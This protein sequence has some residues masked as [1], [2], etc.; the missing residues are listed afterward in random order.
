M[1]VALSLFGCG[2]NSHPNNGV[3]YYCTIP[4]PAGSV[5]EKAGGFVA[6]TD[7]KGNSNWCRDVSGPSSQT[8]CSNACTD[9][10]P[11]F[12]N[13]D[14][15]SKV[16]AIEAGL[17]TLLNLW[18]SDL[19]ATNN[20]CSKGTII[21]PPMYDCVQRLPD[22]TCLKWDNRYTC[23]YTNASNAC[24]SS[25][26]VTKPALGVASAGF[27]N[28]VAA[29]RDEVSVKVQSEQDPSK[30]GEMRAKPG[31]RDLSFNLD[32]PTMHITSLTMPFESFSFDNKW[33]TQGSAM[34]VGSDVTATQTSPFSYSIPQGKASFSLTA[35]D[36]G[37]AAYTL[38]A[39]NSSAITISID[40][41]LGPQI[42]GTLNGAIDGHPV[43]AEIDGAQ[44]WINR[45]PVAI[46]KVTNVTFNSSTFPGAH[47]VTQSCLT[48]NGPKTWTWHGVPGAKV[49]V[50][51]DASPSYN[52]DGGDL[53]YKW[54]LAL[55][56][57]QRI[58]YLSL[59]DGKYNVV[60]TV[61]N[62][63]Y[64]SSINNVKFEVRDLANPGFSGC[65]VDFRIK[66]YDPRNVIKR[67]D[68]LGD[69]IRSV[70]RSY[71][72]SPGSGIAVNAQTRKHLVAIGLP[73]GR[74]VGEAIFDD[75]TRPGLAA[76][77]WR[78]RK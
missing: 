29:L 27:D 56:G 67:L 47:D 48:P 2:S 57:T 46:A 60:L 30:K 39:T 64:V 44:L 50:Q 54:N 34:L 5:L 8:L 45:P 76:V 55:P 51:L 6:L 43:R 1:F 78:Y 17:S 23:L 42:K 3:R 4:P 14:D 66:M 69:P 38:M 53:L 15:C 13:V 65:G 21:G 75:A 24:D 33:F 40:G 74:G 77:R 73:L 7:K 12:K 41:P 59:A 22:G 28:Y 37:A 35:L 25:I 19:N 11:K 26:G 62:H 72:I 63:Y 31:G 70:I 36:E 71:A 58:A 20:L 52:P 61:Q 68:P 32:G 9:M 49:T 10:D 16:K 18:E